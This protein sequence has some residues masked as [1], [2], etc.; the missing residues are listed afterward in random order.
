MESLL[1][2]V[3]VRVSEDVE[4]ILE[5]DVVLVERLVLRES[6]VDKKGDVK[7]LDRVMDRMFYLVV[8]GKEGWVFLVD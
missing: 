8:K 5:V 4:V 3:V 2:D 6:E 1:K 7:R